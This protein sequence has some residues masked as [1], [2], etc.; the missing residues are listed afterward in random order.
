MTTRPERKAAVLVP[1]HDR[2]CAW[3]RRTPITYAAARMT[4]SGKATS[5][6]QSVT[7][8]SH[9]GTG[10]ATSA[11]TGSQGHRITG[12]RQPGGRFHH[13]PGSLHP[14]SVL[15]QPVGRRRWRLCRPSPQEPEPATAAVAALPTAAA[16]PELATAPETATTGDPWTVERPRPL[17][18]RDPPCPN[19]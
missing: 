1:G 9:D 12:S 17:R 2:P 5:S 13:A 4:T 16:E 14:R 6:D 8:M 18:R 19:L 10:G 15:C 11:L 3:S 7:R